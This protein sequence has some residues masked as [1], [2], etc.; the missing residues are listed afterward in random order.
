[1]P[2]RKTIPTEWV[3]RLEALKAFKS[4]T[5]LSTVHPPQHED[6]TPTMNI[7][8]YPLGVVGGTF[9]AIHVAVPD[10]KAPMAY[11]YMQPSDLPDTVEVTSVARPWWRFWER[12]RSAT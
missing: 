7:W 4:A 2:Q 10:G 12:R 9:Y 11:M 8:H 1:M 6:R 3:E 5:E